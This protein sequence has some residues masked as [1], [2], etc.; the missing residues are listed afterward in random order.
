MLQS[1]SRT[2]PP[3][4]PL[5]LLRLCFEH[6]LCSCSIL[7]MIFHG[8][9]RASTLSALVHVRVHFHIFLIV[10]VCCT[11]WFFHTGGPDLYWNSPPVFTVTGST[12][13]SLPSDFMENGMT[14]PEPIHI[15]I[16][17]TAPQEV[18]QRQDFFIWRTLLLILTGKG[19]QPF[20]LC[21]SCLVC[22]KIL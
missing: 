13:E 14:E 4:L 19:C 18:Q 21:H 9:V 7:V 2:S 1:L 3:S 22:Y 17:S 6:R 15:S 20:L 11:K 10:R 12:I 8:C 16:C 5:S